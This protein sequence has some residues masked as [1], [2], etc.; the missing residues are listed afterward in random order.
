MNC[1]IACLAGTTAIVCVPAIRVTRGLPSWYGFV[2]ALP[3]GCAHN[4]ECVALE[5]AFEINF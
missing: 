2:P 3:E 5:N 1:F 4:P